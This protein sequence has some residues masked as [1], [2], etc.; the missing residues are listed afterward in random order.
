MCFRNDDGE[1]E[2][3]EIEP[4]STPPDLPDAM[5]TIPN[6]NTTGREP[7]DAEPNLIASS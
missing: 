5:K 1:F 4:L 3:L 2:S 6:S 7:M